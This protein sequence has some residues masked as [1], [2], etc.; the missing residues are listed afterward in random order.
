MRIRIYVFGH[1]G[2]FYHQAK[3]VRKTLV[4]IVLWLFH[5]F[6]SWKNYVNVPLKSTKQKKLK[7]KKYQN[8]TDPQHWQKVL[9]KIVPAWITPGNQF[10]AVVP[11]GKKETAI[12]F[13]EFNIIGTVPYFSLLYDHL[14]TLFNISSF[15]NH[16]SL[17]TSA[18]HFPEKR[19]YGKSHSDENPKQ[20]WNWNEK[21]P[22]LNIFVMLL[23]TKKIKLHIILRLQ[24]ISFLTK[25]YWS[26]KIVLF[27]KLGCLEQADRWQPCWCAHT[28]P[29]HEAFSS[30]CRAATGKGTISVLQQEKELLRC[31]NRTRNY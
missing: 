16:L 13:C 21:K 25:Y 17:F 18:F 23:L 12:S 22:S 10:V 30:H 20:G 11:H 28:A 7:G 8:V 4:P 27:A 2:S 24:T 15:K 19:V 1:P 14:Y 9:G 31:C 26:V 29:S 6:L 3:M 5:D